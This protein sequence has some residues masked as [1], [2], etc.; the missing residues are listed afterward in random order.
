MSLL[1][2]KVTQPMLFEMMHNVL[3]ETEDGEIGNFEK[4]ARQSLRGESGSRRSEQAAHDVKAFEPARMQMSIAA[5]LPNPVPT[6]GLR[7]TAPVLLRPNDR[8]RTSEAMGLVTEG[9]GRDGL[10]N[11]VLP[12]SGTS[13][14]AVASSSLVSVSVGDASSPLFVP[15]PLETLLLP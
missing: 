9:T 5:V 13:S 6:L 3:T 1:P 10:A 4:R 11:S 12:S 2:P 14:G 8:D 7:L 15:K